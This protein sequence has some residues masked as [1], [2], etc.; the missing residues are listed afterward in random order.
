[1]DTDSIAAAPSVDNGNMPIDTPSEP[2]P[3]APTDGTE[4]VAPTEPT[5]D[6]YELPDGRKVDAETLSKEWKENFYPDYTRKS[7]ALA[8]RDAAPAAKITTE[9]PK[10]SPYADPNFVPS[11][12][13]ELIQAAEDRALARIDARDRE[14]TERRQAIETTVS[15]QLTELKASD[16]TLNENLLF[17]HAN[18]Y[19]FRD[20]KLAH[21][22]MKDMSAQ[23]KQV[24]QVTAKNIAKRADPV[25]IQPGATGT[26]SNPSNFSSA[27][28]YLR[29]LNG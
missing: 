28:E 29:S 9:T 15:T 18:K 22:N 24:Q 23:A 6:L 1:M 16:P 7:Q 27:K 26:Q 19:G 5:E 2:T 13:E 14:A 4:P 17:Q 10:D 21:Q 12:Y 3:V 11:S 25:S 20:L 8:A